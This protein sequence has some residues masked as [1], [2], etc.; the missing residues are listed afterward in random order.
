MVLD[1]LFCSLCVCGFPPGSPMFFSIRHHV[2]LFKVTG[3]G[4]L[5]QKGGFRPG[6]YTSLSEGIERHIKRLT[7]HAHI[8]KYDKMQSP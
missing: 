8:Y 5:S 2:K 1:G 7:F 4:N 3:V 6:R